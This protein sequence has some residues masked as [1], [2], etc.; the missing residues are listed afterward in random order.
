MKTIIKRVKIK[1]Q[2]LLKTNPLKAIND[3]KTLRV[4]DS[5]NFP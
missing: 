2:L 1:D 4:P 3:K 5:Q